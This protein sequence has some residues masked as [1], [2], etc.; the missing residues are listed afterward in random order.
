MSIYHTLY[1]DTYV[2]VAAWYNYVDVTVL[3]IYGNMHIYN[4][5]SIGM[6]A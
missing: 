5:L 6:H 4:Q 1:V 3:D 2:Y